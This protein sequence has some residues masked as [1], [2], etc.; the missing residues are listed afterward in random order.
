MIDSWLSHAFRFEILISARYYPCKVCGQH[1]SQLMDEFPPV[2]QSRQSFM[3]WMCQAHNK[4][5][6][7]LQKP[8]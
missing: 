4:V 1:F 2:I 8:M 7:R 3:L 5:N 6:Q